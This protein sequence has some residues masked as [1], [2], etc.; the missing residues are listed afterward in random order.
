MKKSK[1]TIKNISNCQLT[2]R[3]VF[4]KDMKQLKEIIDVNM[5]KGVKSGPII[6]GLY[7]RLSKIFH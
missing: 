2:K 7:A 4:K 5:V 6:L 3:D 1:E